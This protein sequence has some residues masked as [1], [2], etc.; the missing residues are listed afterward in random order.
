VKRA[1]DV[2]LSAVAL[3][4]LSPLLLAVAIGVKCAISGP[5][6]YKQSRVGQRGRMVSVR[7]F[8]SMPAFEDADTR[9]QVDEQQIPWFGR[10]I[11]KTSLDEL[12]QLLNVLQGDMTLVGPRP[13]R[14]PYVHKFTEEIAGYGARHRVPVGLTGWA[15]VHGLRGDTSIEDRARFDNHYIEHWSLWLDL[16]IMART[17]G[18]V[19][20]TVSGWCRRRPGTARAPATIDL[21][22]T[23][24]E[25]GA[26]NL[27]VAPPDGGPEMSDHLAIK[28]S[29]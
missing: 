15:Q 17:I 23:A 8:R 24:P 26:M 27:T 2:V 16:V 18:H 12:P 3:L 11:R 21:T 22:A 10:F 9:W 25:L 29:S 7:K 28:E 6:L 1:L 20:R 19:L 4:L 14:E 5:V 13:E